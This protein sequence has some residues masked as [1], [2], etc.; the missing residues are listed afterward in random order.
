MTRTERPAAEQ[1]SLGDLVAAAT[2]DLSK[3]V[4]TE[5]ELAKM[6]LVSDAKKAAIGAGLFAFAG[7]IGALVVI[8]LSIAFAY[9][10][11][12][13]GMWHWAAFVLVAAIYIVLAAAAVGIGYLRMRK[14]S[15]APRTRRTLADGVKMIRRS[16][17]D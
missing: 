5:I 9:G 12:G 10:L 4:R 3:L 13:L 17:S 16:S 14:I 8:L 6:E 15:G 7:L 2:G 11:V 1:Q